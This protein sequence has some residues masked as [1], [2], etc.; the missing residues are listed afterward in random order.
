MAGKIKR[1]FFALVDQTLSRGIRKSSKSNHKNRIDWFEPKF[2][3]KEV[4][5][6]TDAYLPVSD[7][8][9]ATN[10]RT[11]SWVST[12]DKSRGQKRYMVFDLE[13]WDRGK[14]SEEEVIAT[15]HLIPSL[16][17]YSDFVANELRN[18]ANRIPAGMF[19]LGVNRE[20]FFPDPMVQ[21][22]DSNIHICMMM[23]RKPHKGMKEGLKVLESIHNVRP[24]VTIVGFGSREVTD[25]IPSY[26]KFHLSPSD[27]ELRKIYSSSHIFLSSSKRE[28]FNLPPMEAMACGC[29]VVVTNT[30]AVSEYVISGE[31][32]FIREPGD[33]EGLVKDIVHLIDH[34]NELR[35]IASNSICS[36]KK[37]SWDNAAR[38]FEEAIQNA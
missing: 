15:Y 24:K 6:L 1:N 23:H 32:A 26:M 33:I 29:A 22:S 25:A 16:V 36:I 38:L 28:G 7:Y 8:V 30:G 10:W 19:T 35:Q 31:T 20:K 3:F 11:A 27:E 4:R 13:T 37:Y 14:F 12:L 18:K 5:F 2:T 9:I 34:P 17:T 21:K